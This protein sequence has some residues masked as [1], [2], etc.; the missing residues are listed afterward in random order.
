MS[1]DRRLG[2]SEEGFGSRGAGELMQFLSH[3]RGSGRSTTP[4]N[5]ASN[6]E[7][8]PQIMKALQLQ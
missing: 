4:E 8:G 5:R 3:E 2:D 6:N 7:T 1:G